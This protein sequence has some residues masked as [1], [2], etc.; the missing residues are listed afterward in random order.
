MPDQDDLKKVNEKMQQAWE[1]MKAVA[2]EA[3][4]AAEKVGGENAELKTAQAKHEAGMQK[5]EDE[6]KEL[7]TAAQ[8][9]QME[10]GDNRNLSPRE[11]EKKRLVDLFWTGMKAGMSTLQDDEKKQVDGNFNTQKLVHMDPSERS[12]LVVFGAGTKALSIG[13]ETA[14]G[15]LAP[16]EFVQDIIKG[17]QLISPI[18]P[19][20]QVRTTS[21]RSVQYPVRSGVFSAL[22]VTQTG[23]P[24][25]TPAGTS[26]TWLMNRATIG[27]VRA[28]VGPQCRFLWEPG[29][30]DGTP[31]NL[32]GSPYVEVPDMPNVPTGA[33]AS[34]TYF[35]IIYGNIKRGYLIVD[36][37]N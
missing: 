32:L 16:P 14:G 26:A 6:L 17:V 21:R 33:S 15:Y 23:T 27:A 3:K 5:L 19:L 24:T 29:L 11:Q 31:P 36:R 30:A 35:P 4:T 22:S 28:L 7:R 10:T 34:G 20:A 13:D 1:A 8:R 12:K 2:L 37:I 9:P 18:R 25:Q